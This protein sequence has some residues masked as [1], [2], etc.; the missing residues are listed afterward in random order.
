MAICGTI[1]ILDPVFERHCVLGHERIAF[2]ALKQKKN[3]KQAIL[4][5]FKL[6]LESSKPHRPIQHKT[7]I[8]LSPT[9]RHTH[10]FK[11]RHFPGKTPQARAPADASTPN[12]TFR[13]TDQSSVTGLHE[14]IDKKIRTFFKFFSGARPQNTAEFRGKKPQLFRVLE[15]TE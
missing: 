1:L 9:F 14:L 13:L 2:I 4:I 15:R 10:L 5:E 11:G 7:K 12:L 3:Q 8:K 6:V